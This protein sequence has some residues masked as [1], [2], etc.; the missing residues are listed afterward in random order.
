MQTSTSPVSRI[1]VLR[2]LVLRVTVLLV[3]A[4]SVSLFAQDAQT[5]CNFEDGNQVTIQYH[6]IVKEE[7]H[8][9]RVWAPGITLYVQTPLMLGN[10]EIPLGAFSIYLIPDRK[11]WT[12]IVNKNVT[13]G[14]DYN[15]AQDVAKAQMEVGEL[16]QPTKQLQLSFAHMSA[17]Q[18]NLRVYYQKQGAFVDFLEK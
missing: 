13:A 17:K 12:I 10:S 9:G 5:F 3:V 11:A 16:P 6:P 7:P 14:A 2:I 15:S 1:N 8:N 18:C 4:S